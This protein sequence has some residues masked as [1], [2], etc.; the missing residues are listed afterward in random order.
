ML[1]AIEIFNSAVPWLLGGCALIIAT[2]QLQ[3]SRGSSAILFGIG[4][5]IG[6]LLI[7]L[8]MMICDELGIS[9]FQSPLLILQITL[10]LAAGTLIWQSGPS[11]FPAMRI[12]FS[13]PPD[14]TTLLIGAIFI[15]LLVSCAVI[16]VTPIHA[17]DVLDFWGPV[18]LEIYEYQANSTES[19]QLEHPRSLR[20]PLTIS[21]ILAWSMG[22][23][24]GN[25]ISLAGL[26]WLLFALS[27]LLITYG[28]TVRLCR[29]KLL[30]VLLGFIFLN[31]PL[32]TNHVF[33]AGYGELILGVGLLAAT[34]LFILGFYERKRVFWAIGATILF[35][36]ATLKNTGS[37]YASLPLISIIVLLFSRHLLDI[38]L[39]MSAVILLAICLYYTVPT[40]SVSV[41]G[42][43]LGLNAEEGYLR[44]GGKKLFP[45][46]PES[47]VLLE[48]QFTALFKNQTFSTLPA[49]VICAM[50]GFFDSESRAYKPYQ[51]VSF[52]ILIGTAGVT[53]SL[54]TEHGL[55]HALPGNDTG[56]S[57]FLLP[58]MMCVPV[59]VACTLAPKLSRNLS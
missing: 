49:A 45:V 9:A 54:F 37:F 23:T 44:F 26:P 36:L 31:I 21:Y 41:P 24:Q 15:N 40:F 2:T 22:S 43:D 33:S 27:G 6:Y 19:F 56:H 11:A 8:I 59:L 10:A 34:S 17:W 38:F 51:F 12:A 55:I 32:V 50:V 46:W 53:A 58:I 14:T 39:L 18:A 13:R 29:S 1:Q 4:G 16:S 5:Y 25:D 7:A 30:G 57:R 35:S 48:T 20:H 47:A 28:I 3:D 42:L 52:I